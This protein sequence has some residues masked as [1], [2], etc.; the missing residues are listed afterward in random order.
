MN[1]T[2]RNMATVIIKGKKW[3]K[4]ENCHLATDGINETD[5]KLYLKVGTSKNQLEISLNKLERRQ[6][7]RILD[8]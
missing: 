1:E 2:N 7:I 5:G 4:W 6:L 3:Q 8:Q